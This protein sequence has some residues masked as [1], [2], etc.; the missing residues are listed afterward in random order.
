MPDSASAARPGFMLPV[1][2]YVNRLH[3]LYPR[4]AN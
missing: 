3:Y 4:F 2:A 1:F